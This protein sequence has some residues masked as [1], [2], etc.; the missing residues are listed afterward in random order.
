MTMPKKS[1]ATVFGED[2]VENRFKELTEAHDKEM[3][4]GASLGGHDMTLWQ[5]IP[6]YGNYSHGSSQPGA[7]QIRRHFHVWATNLRAS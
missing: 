1:I 3:E 5:P 4:E 2:K 7:H 6:P